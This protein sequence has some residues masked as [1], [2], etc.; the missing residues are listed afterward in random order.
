MSA[1]LGCERRRTTSY[2]PACNG[3]IERVHRQLKSALRACGRTTWFDALPLALLKTDL[4]CSAAQLVYGTTLRLPG[5]FLERSTAAAP[6]PDSYADGLRRALDQLRPTPPRPS[7]S[8]AHVPRALQDATHVFLRRDA[9]KPPLAC[10][11]DGPFRVVTRSDKTM[12]LDLGRRQDVISIDRVKPAH[13]NLADGDGHSEQHQPRPP[14]TGVPAG[15]PAPAQPLLGPRPLLPVQHLPAGRPTPPRLGAPPVTITAP[16]V[17]PTAPPETPTAPPG[18]PTVP[19]EAQPCLPAR[20]TRPPAVPPTASS[21][22]PVP[23]SILR[24]RS[25]RPVN[26]PARYRVTFLQQASDQ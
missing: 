1:L 8:A 3:M 22:V 4:G 14:P 25:G 2:H 5:Q 26:R 24:T 9:T 23:H 7:S 18:T 15:R 17:T 19:P 20:V 13:L 6:T 12:T 16:P 21:S 11:Y 10:R